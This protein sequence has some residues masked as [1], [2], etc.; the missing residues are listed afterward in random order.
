MSDNHTTDELLNKL[1]AQISELANNVNSLVV[2]EA[3]R[4]EREK[5]QEKKND[6]FERHIEKYTPVLDRSNRTQVFWDKALVPLVVMFI[7]TALYAMD[8]NIKG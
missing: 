6:A 1:I 5:F 4:S 3:A 8:I 2:V 7:V